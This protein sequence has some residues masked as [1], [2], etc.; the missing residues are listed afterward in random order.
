SG[1]STARSYTVDTAVFAIISATVNGRQL[2]LQY[3]DE[4]AL[5]PEQAHNAPN[6]A[7]VVLVDGVRNNVTGVLVDAAAKT[8]TLT[9][10]S[11]VTRG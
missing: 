3:S 7:F 5:D 9:L 8:I 4:T 2:V 1:T 11:A 10:D 6:D